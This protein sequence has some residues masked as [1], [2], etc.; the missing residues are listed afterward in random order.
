MAEEQV[1]LAQRCLAG[2]ESALR[3]F[4]DAFQTQ[5]F[6]LCLRMLRHR[7]D[8]ED[9][10]Q[11]S[12]IRAIRYL[13]SWDPDYPLRPWVLKIA[14]NRCR[15]ALSKRSRTPTPTAH[16]PESVSDQQSPQLGLAEELELAMQELK[17]EHLECFVLFYQNELSIQEIAELM[18]VPDGTIKTWLHRSRKQLA[19]TL[20][21]RGTTPSAD[22]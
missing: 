12:L 16:L 1:E 20:R 7:Q 19:E 4:V 11:E 10:A 22:N 13:K 9:I 17:A 21:K 6:D 5:V 3:E 18:S 14:A 2:E 15:T 8:A